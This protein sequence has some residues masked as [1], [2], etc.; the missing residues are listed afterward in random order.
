AQYSEVDEDGKKIIN[1]QFSKKYDYPKNSKPEY[2]CALAVADL[3]TSKLA[4]DFDLDVEYLTNNTTSIP[5]S[6]VKM[7]NIIVNGQVS[8]KSCVY[9]LEE[10]M[11]IWSG[12]LHAIPIGNNQVGYMTG[13]TT[14]PDSRKLIKKNVDNTTVQDFRP[15]ERI[16]K[17][18]FDLSFIQT[19]NISL[20][21][22]YKFTRDRTDVLKQPA[23]FSQNWISR[24][25]DGSAKLLFG[26]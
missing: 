12:H 21:E 18:K 8:S 15:V 9:Y 20:S 3:D 22:A 19:G 24:G 17:L 5:R 11:S 1:Y 13:L 14:T 25:Y 6:K 23:Y 26:M 2:L 7:Q 16:S 10:D 4:A